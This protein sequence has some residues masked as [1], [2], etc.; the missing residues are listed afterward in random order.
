LGAAYRTAAAKPACL[1]VELA[2]VLSPCAQPVTLQRN[3]RVIA[4]AFPARLKRLKLV[5]TT[6]VVNAVRLL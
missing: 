1:R 6:P 4:R 3:A 2:G 5:F